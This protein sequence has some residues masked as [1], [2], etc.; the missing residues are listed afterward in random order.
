MQVSC[1]SSYTF[2]VSANRIRISTS[3]SSDANPNF[4]TSKSARILTGLIF[5]MFVLQMITIG[6]QC[7]TAWFVL[8]SSSRDSAFQALN[9]SLPFEVLAEITTTLNTAIADSIMVN[10]FAFDNNSTKTDSLPFRYGDVGSSAIP[11]GK[12]P[13]YRLFWIHSQLVCTTLFVLCPP[14]WIS[15]S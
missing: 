10:Y 6:V 15:I 8:K 3:L 11:A 14:R 12:Q 2:T 13:E 7:S 5:L 9:E 1:F 4:R